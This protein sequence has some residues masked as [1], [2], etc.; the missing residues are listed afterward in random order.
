MGLG[1]KKKELNEVMDMDSIDKT[2]KVEKS[3][4]MSNKKSIDP[5]IVIER[6]KE[7]PEEKYKRMWGKNPPANWDSSAYE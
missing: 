6:I 7:T 4:M 3:D 5:G 2:K 1:S